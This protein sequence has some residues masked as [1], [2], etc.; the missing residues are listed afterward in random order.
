MDSEPNSL[1]FLC[2]NTSIQIHLPLQPVVYIFLIPFLKF[3]T[4]FSRSIFS[5]K[6]CMSFRPNVFTYGL[7]SRA[8]CNQKRVM[9]VRLHYF[10]L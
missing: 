6:V 7:Y 3:I 1:D 5:I 10:N 8:V 2:Q 4:L 9:L